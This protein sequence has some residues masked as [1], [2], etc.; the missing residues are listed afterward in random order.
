MIQATRSNINDQKAIQIASKA[1]T[2]GDPLE[3]ALLKLASR[4]MMTR[5]EMEEKFPEE[6]EE[7]FDSDIKMMATYNRLESGY[8]VSVKGA[9]EN[10]INA[11]SILLTA[12]GEHE[13]NEEKRKFSLEK[14]DAM[15]AVHVQTDK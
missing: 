1:K 15:A 2:V 10:V 11:C 8:R 12:E 5:K 9:P 6:K 7:A 13:L 3:V 4:F 14:N